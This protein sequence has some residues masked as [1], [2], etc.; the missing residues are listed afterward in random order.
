MMESND[1]VKGSEI[2]VVWIGWYP[3]YCIS[4]AAVLEAVLSKSNVAKPSFYKYI[5]LRDGLVTSDPDK[6]RLHCNLIEPFFIA[7][8]QKY[9]AE[10]MNKEISKLPHHIRTKVGVPCDIKQLINLSAINIITE[11]FLNIPSDELIDIKYSWLDNIEKGKGIESAQIIAEKYRQA[12]LER[13]NN[14]NEND[15][16][17]KRKEF[18]SLYELLN[19]KETKEVNMDK[20]EIFDELMTI[21]AAGHE[22]ISVAMQWTLFLLGNNPQIQDRLYK[23]IV[24]LFPGDTSVDDLEKISQ[25]QFLDQCIKESLRLKPPAHAIARKLEEDVIINGSKLLKDSIVTINLSAT[26]YDPKFFPNPLKY[27]PDRWSFIQKDTLP[28]GAYVPFSLGPR[29]Y[30]GYRFALLG[31]KVYLIHII[32]KSTFKSTRKEDEIGH[33]F[34]ASLKPTSS[35]ELVFKMRE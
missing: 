10:I 2:S 9:F 1:P 5:G 26:H 31:M 19:E 27:D 12:A 29:N 23:E 18:E 8:R 24:D 33:R 3:I 16:K 7:K 17:N 25:C 11:V 14:N 28:K 6:W 35:L 34:E 22:T 30:I 4:G 13:G 15:S 20:E 21:I 32:R